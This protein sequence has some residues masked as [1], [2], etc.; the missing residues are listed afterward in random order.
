[1]FTSWLIAAS[2]TGAPWPRTPIPPTRRQKMETLVQRA[3]WVGQDGGGLSD[4]ASVIQRGETKLWHHPWHLPLVSLLISG[5]LNWQVRTEV[6]NWF[7]KRSIKPKRLDENQKRNEDTFVCPP[8][9]CSPRL[10]IISWSLGFISRDPLAASTTITVIK[11]RWELE[12]VVVPPS[13]CR[14]CCGVSVL[15]VW[16]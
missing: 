16:S 12:A 4:Q 10:L 8:L 9:P 5:F 11:Q 2:G 3:G 15:T 6:N 7:N 1:M 13:A 14:G